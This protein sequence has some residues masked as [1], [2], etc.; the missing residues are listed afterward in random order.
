ML[1]RL[2]R[3][4]QVSIVMILLPAD[5]SSYCLRQRIA[6]SEIVTLLPRPSEAIWE[7]TDT[8]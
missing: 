2:R 4:R 7:K 5:W 8:V 1:L 6:N 3:H